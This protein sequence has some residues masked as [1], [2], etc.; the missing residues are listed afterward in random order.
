[1]HQTDF[2]YQSVGSM[3]GRQ[4]LFYQ[5]HQSGQY[6]FF[7]AEMSI[8]LVYLAELMRKKKIT[9]KDFDSLKYLQIIS[10]IKVLNYL[11]SFSCLRSPNKSNNPIK[12]WKIKE[13]FSHLRLQLLASLPPF[14]LLK[15]K[16]VN[17]S[18]LKFTISRKY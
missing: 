9:F 16:I 5:Y 10:S 1:M 2:T 11:P 12:K 17:D 8:A 18:L 4:Y 14:G 15:I 13:N 6:Q 7:D 3:V